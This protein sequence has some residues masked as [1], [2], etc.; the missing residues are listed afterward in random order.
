MIVLE[1]S[2]LVALIRGEPNSKHIA[3]VL[4]SAESVSISAFSLYE[5][6]VVL[7]GKGDIDDPKAAIQD[8]LDWSNA[9]VIAFDE[10][11]ADLAYEAYLKFGK[12]SGSA[13]K[14]NL[15]DCA[16]YALSLHLNAPLLFIGSDFSHTDVVSALP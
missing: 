16:A 2:A 14:L 6:G 15:A 4:L 12:G 1:T 9:K 10:G 3:E 13:A 8:V 5:A 7:R 11:Q